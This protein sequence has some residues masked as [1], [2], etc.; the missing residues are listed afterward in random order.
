MPPWLMINHRKVIIWRCRCLKNFVLHIL[1][2]L[3]QVSRPN[4]RYTWF[5]LTFH[6]RVYGFVFDFDL[7]IYSKVQDI[8]YFICS[9]MQSVNEIK[10]D[11]FFFYS[12]V[13]F[14]HTVNRGLR[15]LCEWCDLNLP[16][17][18]MRKMKDIWMIQSSL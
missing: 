17:F 6:T 11:F 8:K 2:F 12:F 16:Q 18:V 4:T 5:H 9:L 1:N 13:G 7:F 14:S 10:N 15:L 3:S